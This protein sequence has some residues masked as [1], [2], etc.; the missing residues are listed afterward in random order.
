MDANKMAYGPIIYHKTCQCTRVQN[1]STHE[2]I[3]NMPC[4][5]Q[6]MYKYIQNASSARLGRE[7]LARTRTAISPYLDPAEKT[8]EKGGTTRVSTRKY[9]VRI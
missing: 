8:P 3:I 6:V 2:L 9:L 1:M 4:M 5:P 7:R